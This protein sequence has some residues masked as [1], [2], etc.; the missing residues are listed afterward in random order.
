MS[1]KLVPSFLLAFSLSVNWLA[2]P[3]AVLLAGLPGILVILLS[4]AGILVILA[5]FDV[6]WLGISKDDRWLE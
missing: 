4:L 3:L 1:I 5:G 6:S 2:T